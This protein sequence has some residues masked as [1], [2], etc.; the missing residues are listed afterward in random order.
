MVKVDLIEWRKVNRAIIVS[1]IASHH[2]MRPR[3]LLRNS[4]SRCVSWKWRRSERKGH[5]ESWLSRWG[6]NDILRDFPGAICILSRSNVLGDREDP[7]KSHV[8]LW[9]NTVPALNDACGSWLW[10][11]ALSTTEV[12]DVQICQKRAGNV[13]GE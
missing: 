11:V 9:V 3:C 7:L 13:W 4:A 12:D 2:T 10:Q 1:P 5:I 6:N 8:S